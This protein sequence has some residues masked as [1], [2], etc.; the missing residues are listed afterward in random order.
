MKEFNYIIN[1]EYHRVLF[2]ITKVIFPIG[3]HIRINI[4][5]IIFISIY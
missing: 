4:M 5:T 1:W 2:K 3:K